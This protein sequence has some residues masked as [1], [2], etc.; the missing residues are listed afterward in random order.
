VPWAGVLIFLEAEPNNGLVGGS[1]YTLMGAFSARFSLEEKDKAL[2]LTLM[3]GI[4]GDT[5]VFLE[6]SSTVLSVGTKGAVTALDSG[7][8]PEAAV[9]N[10]RVAVSLAP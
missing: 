4:G 6:S 8:G 9:L 2:G 10:G 1:S 7:R 3:S 5:T